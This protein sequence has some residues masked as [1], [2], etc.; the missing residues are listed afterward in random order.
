MCSPSTGSKQEAAATKE[1]ASQ[2][3]GQAGTVFGNDNDVFNRMK[4]ANDAT[5]VSGPSQHG[6]S[7]GERA[8]RNAATITNQANAARFA[9]GATRTAQ[10]GFGGG[11]TVSGAGVTTGQN[12]E[13]AQRSAEATAAELGENTRQDWEQGNKNFL[14]AENAEMGATKVFDNMSALDNAATQGN[15]QASRDQAALDA[16]SNWGR[17]FAA[18]LVTSAVGSISSGLTGGILGSKGPKTSAASPAGSGDPATGGGTW[19]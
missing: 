14:N 17:N 11:N 15:E 12:L 5:I 16:Q 7:E 10:A 18:G 8:E 2:M 13:V 9:A 1:F 6:W 19:G 3:M 4:A